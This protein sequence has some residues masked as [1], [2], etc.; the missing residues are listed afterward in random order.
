M[1]WSMQTLVK[2]IVSR[3]PIRYQQLSPCCVIDTEQWKIECRPNSKDDSKIGEKNIF[4]IR[5]IHESKL[6]LVS[7]PLDTSKINP[8]LINLYN[9]NGHWLNFLKEL[10]SKTWNQE[11]WRQMTISNHSMQLLRPKSSRCIQPPNEGSVI[12]QFILILLFVPY[13]CF[14]S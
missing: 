10:G 14:L 11:I 3:W 4:S 1:C 7:K 9:E 12:P 2:H 5:K 13:F 6:L 8:T